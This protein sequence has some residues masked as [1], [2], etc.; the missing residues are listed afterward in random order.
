M[1]RRGR[2]AREPATPATP[3]S[4]PLG[5]QRPERFCRPRSSATPG[6][7][8]SR[9]A[10]PAGGSRTRDRSPG[11]GRRP[12]AHAPRGPAPIRDRHQRTASPHLSGGT[13]CRCLAKKLPR[14][15][16]GPIHG[17]QRPPRNE[18]RATGPRSP[19]HPRQREERLG[20]LVDPR[21]RGAPKTGEGTR[22]S[23]LQGS[24]ARAGAPPKRDSGRGREGKRTPEAPPTH[25]APTAHAKRSAARSLEEG[26]RGRR[27]RVGRPGHARAPG[28]DP[29]RPPRAS[30]HGP[31]PG[32]H[33]RNGTPES[34][35]RRHRP[36]RARTRAGDHLPGH[37]RGRCTVNV[38]RSGPPG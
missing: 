26:K 32:P 16:A 28:R 7:R 2:A 37:T 1:A 15:S 24:Q 29:P 38:S 11:I 22:C 34:R 19:P 10:G 23:L 25:G 9:R 8:A 14:P 5:C 30:P 20:H 31:G 36:T 17:P 3:P 6:L 35:V 13:K 21:G 12:H 33:P 27:S 18:A 4:A